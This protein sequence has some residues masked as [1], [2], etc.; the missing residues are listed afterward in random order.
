LNGEG[1]RAENQVVLAN[2][3]I[4]LTLLHPG[5]PVSDCLSM[6]SESLK[7]GYALKSFNHLILL[8]QQPATDN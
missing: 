7:S 3:A 1:T 6:A 4:A 8:N 2:A 5:L